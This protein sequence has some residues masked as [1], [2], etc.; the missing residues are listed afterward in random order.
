[1][2]VKDAATVVIGGLIGEDLS[3]SNQQVPCLGNIPGLG[4]LFKSQSSSG[5]K[6]NLYIFITPHII[7]N[8]GEA[9]KIYKEK[10]VEISNLKEETIKLY[11]DVN[12]LK[13]IG[14]STEE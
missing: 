10:N 4:Y 14:V 8:P 6:T 7:T 12:K 9:E 1:M 13:D 3:T 2:V 5:T 11:K